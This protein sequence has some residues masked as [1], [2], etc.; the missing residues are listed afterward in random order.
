MQ[1]NQ[2]KGEFERLLAEL[3]KPA[4]RPRLLVKSSVIKDARAA[5]K[6]QNASRP[7]LGLLIKA[8]VEDAVRAGKLSGTTA[9]DG[10][11]ALG[12]EG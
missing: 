3:N 4:E 1:T 12:L 7:A 6:V 8:A 5:A 11:R 9:V 10:L 2:P